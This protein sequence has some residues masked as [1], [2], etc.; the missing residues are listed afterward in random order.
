MLATTAVSP[1][2]FL[3]RNALV[4]FAKNRSIACQS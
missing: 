3:R 1:S 2:F 4:S